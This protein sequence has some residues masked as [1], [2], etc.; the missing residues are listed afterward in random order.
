MKSFIS[1]HIQ[2]F[3]LFFT[4]FEIVIRSEESGMEKEEYGVVVR[5]STALW[6][7]YRYEWPCED[8]GEGL[9]QS[10]TCAERAGRP[11]PV[12]SSWKET[13]G[14]TQPV[15]YL[16]TGY[17]KILWWKSETEWGRER[18]RGINQQLGFNFFS[19]QL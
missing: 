5:S 4:L 9:I 13:L 15:L 10:C 6:K 16:E 7:G 3:L 12:S 19:L 2:Y 17:F 18:E 11:P 8:S 1:S 14:P